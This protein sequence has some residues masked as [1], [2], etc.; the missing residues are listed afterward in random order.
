MV[1]RIFYFKTRSFP[2]LKGTAK[3]L[4]LTSFALLAMS[5]LQLTSKPCNYITLAHLCVMQH[6]DENFRVCRG[7]MTLH[8]VSFGEKQLFQKSRICFKLHVWRINYPLRQA[9]TPT[10]FWFGKYWPVNF[11]GL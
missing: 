10:K 9:G 6:T 5:F 8:N 4:T 3:P 11:V 2:Y 1:S 7:R